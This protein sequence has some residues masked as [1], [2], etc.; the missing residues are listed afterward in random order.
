MSPN[1]RFIPI[2]EPCLTGNELAYVS[3]CVQSGWVSSLGK[4]IG[5][6]ESRFAEF[7]GTHHGVAVSNGTTA[8]H[9]ALAALGIGPGDEVI[10]PSLTF[11]ATA[12]AVHYTGATPVFA[13][14]E[15]LTWN[16]DP[17]DIARRISPRTRAIIPV[18]IYGHPA[19]MQPILALAEKHGLLVIEDAA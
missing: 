9:L 8:L 18:H 19:D 1:E 17:Q 12:N 7:C 10:I 6:F 3:D 14:S 15:S 4:Y 5:E 2:S 11:I 13:D 16:I